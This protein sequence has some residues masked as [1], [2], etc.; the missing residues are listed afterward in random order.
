LD[1]GLL[2]AKISW[3]VDG[4][5][6]P[7]PTDL[8][9]CIEAFEITHEIP[10]RVCGLYT[11]KNKRGAVIA[12]ARVASGERRHDVTVTGKNRRDVVALYELVLGGQI[13]PDVEHKKFEQIEGAL[14]ELMRLRRQVHFLGEQLIQNSKEL[15]SAYMRLTNVRN[16]IDDPLDVDPPSEMRDHTTFSHR[17]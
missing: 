5:D 11:L 6:S 3:G 9:D 14:D 2:F 1:Q 12:R 15:A 13:R 16:A 17:V 10:E 7:I 8:E 4:L